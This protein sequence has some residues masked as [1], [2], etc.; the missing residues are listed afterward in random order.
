M[1]NQPRKQIFCFGY[2]F[3]IFCST[4]S[5]FRHFFDIVFRHLFFDKKCRVWR[6]PFEALRCSR[7]VGHP[8]NLTHGAPGSAPL[9]LGFRPRDV[10]LLAT[11]LDPEPYIVVNSCLIRGA[12]EGPWQKLESQRE[13]E[14]ERL[15]DSCP[16]WS[17]QIIS[18]IRYLALG[19]RERAQIRRHLVTDGDLPIPV[20]LTRGG[21][22]WLPMTSALYSFIL[23]LR[24][25]LNLRP[26]WFQFF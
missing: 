13:R 25:T 9:G 14:R 8:S 19:T 3:N 10:R 2:F 5:V 22:Q 20:T 6:Q 11:G 17:T 12:F 1:R 7:R 21:H 18:R 15:V 4:K 24:P 26:Q 16:S 23:Y